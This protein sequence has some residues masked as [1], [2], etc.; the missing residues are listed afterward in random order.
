[1]AHDLGRAQ[2]V[3]DF[4]F[5]PGMEKRWFAADAALDRE[6][7]ERFGQ[8]LAQAASGAL[9]HW[10][11]SADGAL[12]LVILLDQVPRNVFRGK[13]QAFAFDSHAL[14]IAEAALLRGHDRALPP[15][16]RCFLYL[17]F[18]HSESL[19][20]QR[21]CV[22]LFEQA[23]DDPEGLDYARRHLAVIERFGR[24]PHRNEALERE[25]TPEEEEFLKGPDSRF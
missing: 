15:I 7:A 22:R 13:A 9:D 14:A 4:W 19:P 5:A 24:F 25:T 23:G 6:L 1:M 12:A 18:E 10:V 16:R 11:E 17:P 21:Y 20:D 2:A 3:L 8:D